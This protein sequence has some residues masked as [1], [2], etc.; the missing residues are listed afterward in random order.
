[1]CYTGRLEQDENY[2][3][4]SVFKGVE[5]MVK[6]YIFQ[7]HVGGFAWWLRGHDMEIEEPARC[8]DCI[9]SYNSWHNQSQEERLKEQQEREK[10]FGGNIL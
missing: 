9:E 10:I 8:E 4:S 3:E 6:L 7:N 2:F 5:K 1:M